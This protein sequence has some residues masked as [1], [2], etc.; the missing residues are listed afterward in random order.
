MPN[1]LALSHTADSSSDLF[2]GRRL[3]TLCE[4]SAKMNILH[5]S[6]LQFIQ[7]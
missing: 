5:Y 7:L 1:A 6:D 3:S 2:H 4:Q